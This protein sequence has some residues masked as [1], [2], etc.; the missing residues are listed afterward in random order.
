MAAN[1]MLTIP[2]YL[3]AQPAM[4]IYPELHLKEKMTGTVVEFFILDRAD[5]VDVLW[6]MCVITGT[7][8]DGSKLFITS[9]TTGD[10]NRFKVRLGAANVSKLC[11]VTGRYKCELTIINSHNVM[12]TEN[13]YMDFPIQTVLPFMVVVDKAAGRDVNAQQDV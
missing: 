13:N 10:W 4:G 9:S 3:E 12:I 7:R 2:V 6:R 5:L 11:T 1:S 8:P